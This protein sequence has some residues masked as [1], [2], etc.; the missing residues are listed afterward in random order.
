MRYGKKAVEWFSVLIES[1]EVNGYDSESSIVVGKNLNLIDGSHRMALAMYHGLERINDLVIDG[2]RQA[3][4]S[5]DWFLQVGFSNDEVDLIMHT[6]EELKE[7]MSKNFS[8]VIWAPTVSQKEDIIRG[9][10]YFGTVVSSKEY[11]Y[12]SGAYDDMVR[13]IYV[14]DDIE[15]W[16]IEKKLE[17]MRGR[18]NRIVAVE[19][20]LDDSLFRIKK[21]SNQPLSTV[22]E[23]AK[24]SLR[25]RYKVDIE[26]YYFDIILHIADNYAQGI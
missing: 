20:K 3:D 26:N 17:Y 24:R 22:G 13:A 25:E 12:D 1:Y 7:R 19:L 4:Y 10:G 5:F 18:G 21:V 8:C 9:I 15:S 16:K 2:E 14:I 11:Q 6:A 23:R